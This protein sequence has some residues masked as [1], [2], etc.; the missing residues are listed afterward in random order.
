MTDLNRIASN[1]AFLTA[2]QGVAFLCGFG[3]TIL[4]ARALGPES[5][6]LLG[7][8][9]AFVG[10]ATLLVVMGTDTYGSR[11]I[12]R[13]GTTVPALVAN[14]IGFRIVTAALIFPATLAIAWWSDISRAA[15]WVV[16]IQALGIVV[17]IV[18][19]DFVFHG[20]QR[21]GAIALRQAAASVLVL[22]GTAL[23]VAAPDDVFAAAAIPVA[24]IALTSLWILQRLRRLQGG[25]G[26]AF[27]AAAWRR[28]LAVTVPIGLGGMGVAVY[29][30]VDVLM[31]G[32]LVPASDVGRYV[33][34]GRLYIVIVTAGNLL[35]AAFAPALSRMI[36]AEAAARPP[37][38]RRFL[39]VVI[40]AGG[41]PAVAFAAMPTATLGLF[42]GEAYSMAAPAFVIV[43]AG[44]FVFLLSSATS[45][46]LV[47]W[48]DERF[49][50]KALAATAL[51]NAGLNAILIP[52][53]GI[54]GAAIATLASAVCLVGAE[55]WRLARRY[56]ASGFGV[57]AHG[58]ALLA[59]LAAVVL[60]VAAVAPE[61]GLAGRPRLVLPVAGA[62]GFAVMAA[63][64]AATGFVNPRRL[65]A[66]LFRRGAS[67]V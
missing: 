45:T 14:I 26:V 46:A 16:A 61:T 35:A 3:T 48:D 52:A 28:M 37:L 64:A 5:Y 1:F 21:M 8:G 49:H 24:A 39:A 18:S 32:Y 55:L 33:A 12:A 63:A 36:G 66:A 10:F 4:L 59:L 11:E 7:F 25:L 57:L 54:T 65:V 15:F 2:A 19:L 58:C 51:I 60:A 31:L 43:M 20:L 67:G 27:D 6:G 22:A 23:L 38:F 53:A 44:A 40:V 41:P 62:I 50:V 29:Q 34:M 13:A 30:Y 42:F 17:V 9:Q 56:R 47:A